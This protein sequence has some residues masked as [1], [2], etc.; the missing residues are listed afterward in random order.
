MPRTRESSTPPTRR[1]RGRLI[2]AILAGAVAV[3]ALTAAC[4]VSLP[5]ASEPR[6][7]DVVLVLGP[8]TDARLALAHRLLDA[9]E[10]D[11]LMV[12]VG[13]P[14]QVAG[15]WE[16]RPYDVLCARPEPFTT[17]GELMWLRDEMASHG[18]TTATVVTM[19]AAATR[20]RFIAW[21]CDLAGVDVQ[22]TDEAWA[23]NL[24]YDMLYQSGGFARAVAQPGC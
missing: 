24:P 14:G 6:A 21:Q 8:A 2:L 7:S 13:G 18:W 3:W 12:S 19:R 17:R 4:V 22:W 15:C 20:T 5:A 11:H 9:G 16:E 10:A 23:L 1:R